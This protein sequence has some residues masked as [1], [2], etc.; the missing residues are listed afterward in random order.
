MFTSTSPL[1]LFL[2]IVMRDWRIRYSKS[3]P[4]KRAIADPFGS[5]FHATLDGLAGADLR[6]N[7]A[8]ASLSEGCWTADI[9]RL[10][11][12]K[13]GS[14][15]RKTIYLVPRCL[16]HRY[17]RMQRGIML[18]GHLELRTK[19]SRCPILKLLYIF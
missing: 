5:G 6:A 13:Y 15:C 18:S 1:L 9:T 7:N 16:H 17:P 19:G 4:S 12:H 11:A 3:L 2:P 10:S 8:H 14:S